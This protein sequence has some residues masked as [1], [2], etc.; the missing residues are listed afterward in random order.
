MAL[1][2]LTILQKWYLKYTNNAQYKKYKIAKQQESLFWN[3]SDEYFAK[4]SVNLKHPS[5]ENHNKAIT[6][7]LH[8]G[9]CGDIIYALPTILTLTKNGKASIF[10]NTN[11]KKVHEVYHTS[12]YVS[13]NEGMATMLKPLLLFQPEIETCEIYK[14]QNI[15]YDLDTFRSYTFL[16]DRGSISRWYFYVF[17]I[18]AP[19]YNPWLVAPKD[20]SVSN[21]IVIARSKRYRNPLI[22]YNFF[23]KYPN[24]IFIG[25][26]EE[27]N[28]IKLMIP[29]I[30]WKKVVDF[31]EMAS[32]INGCKF[33]VGNQS[34]PFSLAEALKVNRILEVYYK[35]PN[36][37]V[38]GAGANDFMYQPQFE[39]LVEGLYNKL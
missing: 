4:L 14:G 1:K 18:S 16:Q 2:K 13:F 20:L 10:L 23:R 26:E 17:G 39:S 34:F 19:L 36:V 30:K 22:D 12:D 32:L 31:L 7:F 28:D 33:F 3:K 9:N 37:I 25:I 38:E 5:H 24:I 11:P 6:T 27:Y 35:I 15:D 8:S 21:C 29:S